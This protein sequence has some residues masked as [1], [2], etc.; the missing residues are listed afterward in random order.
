MVGAGA[1]GLAAAHFAAVSGARVL[2]LEKMDEA[3]KKI[4]IS[5][6]TRCN[7]LPAEVDLQVRLLGCKDVCRGVLPVYL[8]SCGSATMHAWCGCCAAGIALLVFLY[9]ALC[10]RG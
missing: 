5:G 2:V 7:V 10:F 9:P 8:P 4:C 3:G 6:G 1:A